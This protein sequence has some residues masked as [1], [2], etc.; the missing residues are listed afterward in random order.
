M[1]GDP[2][3]ATVRFSNGGGD[4]DQPDY[5]PD[6]R[7]MA[8]KLYLPDGSRTD[9]VAQTVPRFPVRTPDAFIDLVRAADGG[10]ARLWKL[11]LFLV[12][13]PSVLPA[14]RENAPT[15][16]PPTSYAS[17]T[18]YAIHAFKW[19]GAD[20]GE[21]WI[22]YRW[23]PETPEERIS[24]GEG[25]ERGRDYLQE[26]IAERVARGPARFTLEVQ[27]L[28][29]G[30]PHDDATAGWPDDLETV[31]AGTLELTGLDTEREKGDDVLVFDP[32]RLPDGIEPSDDPVLRFRPPAYGVSVQRRSGMPPPERVT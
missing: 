4:P 8:T 23:V 9:I 31:A 24:P 10:L 19:I 18:Y 26:E 20:G 21:R 3:E 11:P 13:H 15:L 6:V 22:R 1:Q 12:T 30:D 32:L 2:V 29:D 28:R 14:L 16:K 5:A 7:G 25:K 17:I 27:I